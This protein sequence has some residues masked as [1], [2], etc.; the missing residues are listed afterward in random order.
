MEIATSPAPSQLAQTQQP[1]EVLA[2]NLHKSFGS[3]QV[4]RGVD[5]SIARGEIVAVVGASGGGKS[6]LLK[7]V[8]GVLPGQGAY[9]RRRSRIARIAPGG[10]RHPG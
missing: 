7:H 9:K 8:I 1:L 10:P 3:N 6:V 4:L 5:V 2:E